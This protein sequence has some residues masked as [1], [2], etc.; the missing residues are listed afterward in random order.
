MPRCEASKRN[1]QAVAGEGQPGGV[2]K[3]QRVQPRTYEEVKEMVARLNDRDMRL[4]EAY[5]A[6]GSSS[7]GGGF[8][9]GGGSGSRGGGWGG[10]GGGGGG[11]HNPPPGG[12][13][14]Q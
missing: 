9:G 3:I 14:G 13:D 4:R 7:S 10:G 12:P 2:A 5:A 8:G 1:A 6:G 11:G